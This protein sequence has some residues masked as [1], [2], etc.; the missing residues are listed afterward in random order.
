MAEV[1]WL[2]V[3][4]VVSLL[5]VGSDWVTKQES[6]DRIFQREAVSERQLTNETIQIL[7]SFAKI[8]LEVNLG[9]ERLVRLF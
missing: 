6:E 7:Y 5:G 1:S 8:V 4:G 3:G 9:K 2:G